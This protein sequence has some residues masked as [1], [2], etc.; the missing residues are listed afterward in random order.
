MI[1]TNRR[2]LY[3][4]LPKQRSA[5]P[6]ANSAGRALMIANPRQRRTDFLLSKNITIFTKKYFMKRILLSSIVLFCCISSVYSQTDF[7]LI[8]TFSSRVRDGVTPLHV[9][10]YADGT[11]VL[12][13]TGYVYPFEEIRTG[14]NRTV[15]LYDYSTKLYYKTLGVY[16]LSF[17]LLRIIDLTHRGIATHGSYGILDLEYSGKIP[18]NPT[19]VSETLFNSDDLLEFVILTHNGFEI[20]NERG[21]VIFSK[22]YPNYVVQR[23]RIL[24]TDNGNLLEISLHGGFIGTDFVIIDHFS[25]PGYQTSAGTRSTTIEPLNSPFPN[26]ATT[27]INLPYQLPSHATQGIISVYNISGQLIRSLPVSDSA[28]YVQFD[29]TNLPA[30][31]YVYN[32]L[33]NNTLI[34]GYTFI[35]R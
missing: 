30:G 4:E 3:S 14:D 17:N 35:V 11:Q 19:H 1:K 9:F 25:L 5:K 6:I 12:L 15:R 33:V 10:T 16:D 18:E 13:M 24:T 23:A 2:F 21:D 20:V 26:P 22:N 34:K 8:N 7:S 31:S 27:Y 29:T 28:D 32:L